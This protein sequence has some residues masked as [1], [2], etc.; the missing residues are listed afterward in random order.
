MTISNSVLTFVQLFYYCY[1]FV[2]R[3]HHPTNLVR[4]STFLGFYV[5][6]KCWNNLK[7]KKV[8]IIFFYFL[9]YLFFA[10]FVYYYNIKSELRFKFI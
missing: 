10:F 4:G 8:F 7:C 1:A 9:N 6:K 2:K 5:E 3:K